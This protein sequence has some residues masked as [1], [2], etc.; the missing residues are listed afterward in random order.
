MSPWRILMVLL[1]CVG[2]PW[3]TCYT[4]PLRTTIG[5]ITMGH[6]AMADTNGAVFMCRHSMRNVLHR[7]FRTPIVH[8]TIEHVTMTDT[9]GAVILVP[10]FKSSH[11]NSFEYLAS[12]DE[13]YGRAILKSVVSVLPKKYHSKN[14]TT[15]GPF[16]ILTSG[17]T[18]FHWNIIVGQSDDNLVPLTASDFIHIFASFPWQ[19]IYG[20]R[21]HGPF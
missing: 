17:T 1:S 4:V 2:I 12:V 8:I 10:Y 18:S 6:V 7:T 19:E 15:L 13:I 3:E 14:G 21:N 5:H 20:V 16:M 9:N 11:C